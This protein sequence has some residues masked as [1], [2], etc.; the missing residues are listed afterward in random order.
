[1]NR[2]RG[3]LMLIAVSLLAAL[4]LELFPLPSMLQFWQ[5]PWLLLTVLFW[6]LHQPG[7]MGLTAAWGAGLV[8]DGALGS[9]L[10]MHALLFTLAA[11]L[12]LA[13]QRL[14]LALPMI[15]Q[16]LWGALLTLLFQLIAFAMEGDFASGPERLPPQLAPAL[17]VL[18]A[19][20]LINIVLLEGRRRL[21][22][23]KF[24][25]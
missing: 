13:T 8:L 7:F 9:P 4:M 23:Q 3:S 24:T 15:Q 25:G 2:K 10:G 6:S 22:R 14:L 17:S 5:P 19:W 21:M 20:P 11:T 12:T 18:L 16:A 1:M